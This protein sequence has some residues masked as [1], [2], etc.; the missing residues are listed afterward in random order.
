MIDMA[1][2]MGAVFSFMLKDEFEIMSLMRFV[3]WFCFFLCVNFLIQR[4]KEGK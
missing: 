3:C 1:L 4:V 2:V